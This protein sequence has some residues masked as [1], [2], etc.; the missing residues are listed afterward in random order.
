MQFLAV[1]LLAFLA[2]WT[3]PVRYGGRSSQ[4]AMRRAQAVALVFAGPSHFL[5]RETFLAHFP[6]WVPYAEAIVYASGVVELALGLALFARRFREWI[7]LAL[8]AYLILIFPANVYVAVAGVEVPGLPEAAW[9]HWVRLPLQALF[10]WWALRSTGA[11]W[12]IRRS[13]RLTVQ[14]EPAH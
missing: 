10:V 13:P 8:A 2:L 4:G 12:P 6:G 7:G 1:L 11:E 14:A 3:L 9:Y 5:K